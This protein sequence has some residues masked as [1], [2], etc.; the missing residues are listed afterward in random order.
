MTSVA[1]SGTRVGFDFNSDGA[2]DA[3][4]L[5]GGA[6][7]STFVLGVI[8]VGADASVAL[9]LVGQEVHAPASTLFG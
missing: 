4:V 8:R 2:E 7:V 9:A 6:A 1:V 5:L 3:F